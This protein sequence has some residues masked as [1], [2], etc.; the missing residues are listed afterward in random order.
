ML[1]VVEIRITVYDVL[2]ALRLA[3]SHYD[4]YAVVGFPN[5]T[6]TAHTLCRL[7]QYDVRIETVNAAQ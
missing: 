3:A 5:I 7:L 4:R 2:R 1:P 6:E